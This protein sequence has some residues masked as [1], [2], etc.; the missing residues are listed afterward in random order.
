L[1]D[2]EDAILRVLAQVFEKDGFT[3]V[4]AN[5]ARQAKAILAEEAAFD[6]VVTDLRMESPLAGYEVVKFASK[7]VPRPVIVILTAFPV[8]PADWKKA[9]ADALCVK[10]MN[11]FGLPK[12]LKALIRQRTSS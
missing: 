1:V 10:G 12:E 11:T 5:S 8:P 3:V 7:L 6:A 2:D 4:T 9:G